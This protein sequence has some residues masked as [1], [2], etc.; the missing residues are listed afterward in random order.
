[1]ERGLCQNG[2]ELTHAFTTRKR[3][4]SGGAKHVEG[5]ANGRKKKVKTRTLERRK[6]AA[7]KFV[8]GVEAASGGK[9]KR[10]PLKTTRVRHPK[11]SW[12]GEAEPPNRRIGLC[13]LVLFLT[14]DFLHYAGDGVVVRQADEIDVLPA[15]DDDGFAKAAAIGIEEFG[16]AIGAD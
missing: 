11:S 6:G 13:R 3:R 5:C 8:L 14:G 2:K 16:G 7:P 15:V 4:P 12:G 1:M 10:A 9:S